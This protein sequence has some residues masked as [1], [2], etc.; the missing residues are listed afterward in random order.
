MNLMDTKRRAAIVAAL[1]EGVGIRATCRMTGASKGT[2]TK[3]IADLGP[4]CAAYQDQ[5]FHDLT[6]KYLQIDEIWSFCFAKSK[7]VPA[8]KQGQFGFGDVWCYTALD[9]ETKLIP[10]WLVGS[11]D[12]GSATELMQDLAGRLSGRAQITTDGLRAYVSAVEDAF[13]GAVDFAQLQK[14]YGSSPE[15]E[16]RYSPAECIGTTV[17]VISGD[18]KPE[19]VSTSYVERS[20]L[21]I[22]MGL[23]RY[24]RLTNG[25]SKKLENHCAALAIYFMYYN[26]VRPHESLRTKKNNRVTPAMAAGVAEKPLTVEDVIRLLPPPV[27]KKRGPYKPRNSK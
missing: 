20:N 22:R 26:F 15:S 6:C 12:V 24:T 25:H 8:S 5:A 14:I 27:A 2:V 10:S 13:G 21:S 17:E 16:R 19:H 4:A 23:R 7:N 18:P 3:L 9:A 11:R 1:V